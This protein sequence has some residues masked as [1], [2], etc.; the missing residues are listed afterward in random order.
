[1]ER[2]GKKLTDAQAAQLR[3]L[4][5]SLTLPAVMEVLNGERDRA[6]TSIRIKSAVY[7][8]YFAVDTPK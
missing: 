4:G 2:C 6:P 3:A 8:P 7:A 5:S 1:M